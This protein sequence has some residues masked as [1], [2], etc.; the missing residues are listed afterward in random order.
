MTNTVRNSKLKVFLTLNGPPIC[1]GMTDAEFR[2]LVMELR[3]EGADLVKERLKRLAE[4]APE[5]RRVSGRGLA[6]MI[7]R[8]VIVSSLD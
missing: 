8:S 1:P 4:W 6:P 7:M 2:K 3:D 5:E